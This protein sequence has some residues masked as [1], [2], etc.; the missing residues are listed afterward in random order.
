MDMWDPSFAGEMHV[1]IADRAD[2][3]VDRSGHG[4][5]RSRASRRAAPTIS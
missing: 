2:L 5:R 4:R 1:A 3:I